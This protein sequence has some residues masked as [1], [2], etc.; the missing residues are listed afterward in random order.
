MPDIIDPLIPPYRF[1]RVQNHLYRGGYPKQ[2]NFR[3]LR[4]QRL[5][6]ILSLIPGD[7]DNA[8][9]EFCEAE[10]ITRITVAV[11]SPNENVT[12]TDSI[13]SQCLALVADPA[14]APLYIH[15][16][17][18]SNVTGVVIMCLRKLQ[19]WRVASYQNEYLRFEQDGEIIPEESEFVETYTGKGLVLPNPYA[20]WLWP[21]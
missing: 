19:L 3:F 21:G 14:R 16:L 11:E 8:L 17:D 7:R 6:T 5:K 4:R 2:R 10:G 9:S 13:V 12:V 15:C 18:G 20:Q 1:E